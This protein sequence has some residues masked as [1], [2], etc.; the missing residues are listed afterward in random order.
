VVSKEPLKPKM[1]YG[2]PPRGEVKGSL[3][4]DMKSCRGN[5]VVYSFTRS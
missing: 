5:S 4:R 2:T 3:S 1:L